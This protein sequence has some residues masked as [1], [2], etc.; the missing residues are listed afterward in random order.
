[1]PLLFISTMMALREMIAVPVPSLEASKLLW[2]D[3]LCSYDPYYILPAT[4]GAV[5]GVTMYTSFK[6][7]M[8]STPNE[9]AVK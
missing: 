2:I 3:S 7:G 4:A 8:L 5:F 1:M 9:T 6:A